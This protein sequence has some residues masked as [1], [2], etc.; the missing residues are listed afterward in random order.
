MKT[1]A[2][3]IV[4]VVVVGACGGGQLSVSEYAAQAEELVDKMVGE[5]AALDAAWEAETPSVRGAERYWEGRMAVRADFLD[6]VKSLEPPDAVAGQHEAAVDVFT[7]ITA[8]DQALADLTA[9]FDT[10]TDHWQWVDS[11]EG[12]ASDALLE[13][14]FAFCRASQAAYDA[15]QDR[16]GLQDLPWIPSEVSE[17]VSVAFG[18]PPA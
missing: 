8:A 11:P 17:V 4:L 10:V 13:E 12:R 5:F 9:T 15:T 1:R 7:R 18:C 3:L 14:V 16:Q 6:G 2:L